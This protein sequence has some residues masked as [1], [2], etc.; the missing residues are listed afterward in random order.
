MP[1]GMLMFNF[2]RRCQLC[3]SDQASQYTVC[4]DCWRQLPWLKHSIMRQQQSIFVACEYAYPLDRIIQQFKYQQQLHWRSLLTGLLLQLR[5][6]KVHAIVAMP[7]SQSRLIQRGYNQSMILA[8]SLAQQLKIPIWQPIQRVA[9]HSQKGLNRLERL[10]HIEAQFLAQPQSKLRF[11][12]VLI[13]DDVVTTGSSIQALQSS[14]LNCGCQEV[15]AVCL[16]ATT[17]Q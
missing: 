13:V 7:I 3:N 4:H 10:A 9:Q 2:L 5:Y 1:H 6:P 12:K 16:A 17:T 15:F 11:R 8:Q 14:L